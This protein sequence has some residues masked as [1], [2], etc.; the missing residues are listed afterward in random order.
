MINETNV[1]S[2]IHIKLYKIKILYN[3]GE[4]NIEKEI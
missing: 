2:H 4:I 3:W 1:C